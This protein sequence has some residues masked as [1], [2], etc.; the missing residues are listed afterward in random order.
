VIAAV[1]AVAPLVFTID[2]G[3]AEAIDIAG[4]DLVLQHAH[5]EPDNPVASI[6]Y[7]VMAVGAIAFLLSFRKRA[8]G[9]PP[10]PNSQPP[11]P[12]WGRSGSDRK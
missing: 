10:N 8:D 1:D 3:D 5:R 6:G 2:R 9:L 7:A 12:R 11:P 4:V